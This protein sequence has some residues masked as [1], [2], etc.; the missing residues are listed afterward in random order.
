MWGG[1]GKKVEVVRGAVLLGPLRSADNLKTSV[2]ELCLFMDILSLSNAARLGSRKG[3]PHWFDLS[4]RVFIK[5]TALTSCRSIY[6]PC[7]APPNLGP[8]NEVVKGV[9]GRLAFYH[10]I[11]PEINAPSQMAVSLWTVR[12]L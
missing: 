6:G 11:C 12:E 10:Q 4:V 5:D 1:G 7:M 2:P 9:S 8:S 3:N